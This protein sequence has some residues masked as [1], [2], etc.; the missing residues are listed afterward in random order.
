MKPLE[1]PSIAGIVKLEKPRPSPSRVSCKRPSRIRAAAPKIVLPSSK[2]TVSLSYASKSFEYDGESSAFAKET[3]N[4]NKVT[5]VTNRVQ[6]S[7]RV[8]FFMEVIMLGLYSGVIL[9]ML[10]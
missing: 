2:L 5:K 4:T 6:K 1:V 3:E 9:K 7:P 8:L 10:I